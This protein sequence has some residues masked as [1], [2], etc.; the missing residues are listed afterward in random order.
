MSNPAGTEDGAQR[1][2]LVVRLERGGA[3]LPEVLGGVVELAGVAV[4]RDLVRPV[5]VHLVVVPHHQP[6]RDRVRGLQV[7][8]GLVLRVPLPV[9]GQA[10]GLGAFVVARVAAADH[11]AALLVLVEVVAQVQHQVRVVLGQPRVGGEVAVLVLRAAGERHGQRRRR[12]V[13]RGAGEGAAHRAEVPAGA[14]PVEVFAPRLQAPQLHVHRVRGFNPGVL[15]AAGYYPAHACVLRHFPRPPRRCGR[16]CR[17]GRPRPRGPAPGGSRCTKPSGHGSP[18]AM[19]SRNGSV[20]R[21][22]SSA[23]ETA[24][25]APGRAATSPAPRPAEM[26]DLRE[27]LSMPSNL[28]RPVGQVLRGM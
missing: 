15:D 8:V 18:E 7:G 14:E 26:R 11:V 3:A 2:V 17:P 12:L 22:A 9:A 28:G 16:A 20:R 25:A 1:H 27:M 23:V 5:V 24:T 19:P 4:L 6:R 13:Q 10:G 21:P